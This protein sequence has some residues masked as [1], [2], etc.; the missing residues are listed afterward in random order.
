M[1]TDLYETLG[2]DRNASSEDVRKAYRRRALQTHPD[3]LPPNITPAQKAAAEDEFRK[4]NNAYEVLNDQQ[5]RRLYDQ[6]GVWPPPSADAGPQRRRS[7]R[8]DSFDPFLSDPFFNSPFGSSR[9]PFA[10]TD[11][12]VLFN[13]LFG[14]IRRNFDDDDPFSSRFPFDNT[15]SDSFGRSLMSPFDGTMLGGSMFGSSMFGPGS[16]FS[17]IMNGESHPHT[18][19]YSSVSRAVGRNGQWVSQSKVTR[20]INGRTETILKRRD[21]EGNEHITYSSPDGERYTINGI[22]QP[23]RD[24]HAITSPPPPSRRNSRP[25]PQAIAAPP[26]EANYAPPPQANNYYTQPQT[27]AYPAY[28]TAPAPAPAAAPPAAQYPS[29][30]Y[31]A[32]VRSPPP[33]Y[34]SPPPAPAPQPVPVPAPAAYAD[35]HA[36]YHSNGQAS[37]GGHYAYEAPQA[38]HREK[39]QA[40][41]KRWWR[42]GWLNGVTSFFKHGGHHK[43]H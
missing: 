2:L 25:P 37:R 18:A 11:P 19:S 7:H 28:T 17:Q 5:N 3:R 10:F 27:Q 32:P 6:H 14:D 16:M 26:P 20:T 9:R 31:P 8:Q 38:S 15:R 29:G 41:E 42:G 35:P 30:F 39:E 21:A 24:G 34:M 40:K 4:V 1:A 33:P 12:F 43:S 23:P 22:E 36:S 13:S